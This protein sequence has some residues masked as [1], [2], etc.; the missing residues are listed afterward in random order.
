MHLM[1]SELRGS[2]ANICTWIALAACIGHQ[3]NN[4]WKLYQPHQA[5]A[6]ARMYMHACMHAVWPCMYNMLN[7]YDI[8]ELQGALCLEACQL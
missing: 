2:D 7:M 5:H 4:L 8:Q 6:Y 3:L 1:L